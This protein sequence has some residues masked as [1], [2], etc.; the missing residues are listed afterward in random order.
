MKSVYIT[1]A[2]RTPIGK[3]NG[4]LSSLS[5]VDLAE[6]VVSA[7]STSS[8]LSQVDDVIMGNVLQAGQGQ[9]IGRQIA[10]R[11]FGDEVPGVT[12][13][14]VCGS[15]LQAIIYGAQSIALGDA[16]TV[17]AGGTESMSN[18]PYLVPKARQGF[19]MGHQTLVD[20]MIQDGLWDCFN[21]YHMGIT[22]ENIGR[23][24][25]VSRD[26]QD[27]FAAE[28]H[29]RALE[30]KSSRA[31]ELEI[32]PVSIPQRKGDPIQVSQD[33]GPRAESTQESLS[34]LRPVFEKDGTVTAGNASSINDGAAA[35]LLQ[36]E[37]SVAET[38]TTPFGKIVSY[39]TAGIDPAVMGLGPVQAIEKALQKAGWSRNDV[40]LVELNEAF[41]VQSLGVLKELPFDP[42]IVNVNGGAIALGHP[43]GASGTRILVTLVHELKRRCL[44]K[45]LVSLCIG[46]GMGIALCVE[47]V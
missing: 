18:S 36:S 41:A 46:G 9:N 28:S 30:A 47:A 26:E 16:N 29:R 40:E 38:G 2:L 14:K 37:E 24:L 4:A 33:E 43:I 13:N 42:S 15:G 27:A 45:G 10:R 32:V 6:T 19:K 11:C 21:D 8:A 1:Q 35:V 22:A 7:I 34:G 44:K 31:F 23:K 17:I 25:N 12:V 5:S 20:S 39:A 3:F